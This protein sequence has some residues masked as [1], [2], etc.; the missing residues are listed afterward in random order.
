MNI[1][2]KNLK[3]IIDI[4]HYASVLNDITIKKEE[5][6]NK[7]IYDLETFEQE[8][9]EL[10]AKVLNNIKNINKEMH[11][12]NVKKIIELG[13]KNKLKLL[14]IHKDKIVLKNR[15]IEPPY[16]KAKKPKIIKIDPELIKQQENQELLTYQ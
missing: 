14:K 10:F 2:N 12:S 15:R 3:R 13:E 4:E 9:K 16:F 1:K 7:L 8:D 5:K 6:I 11:I